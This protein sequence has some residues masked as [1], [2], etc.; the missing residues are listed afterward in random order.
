V[1]NLSRAH[2]YPLEGHE[3]VPE[4]H[5][6]DLVQQ[7]DPS[8]LDTLTLDD[9][10]TWSYMNQSSYA[11]SDQ[12]FADEA[13]GMALPMLVSDPPPLYPFVETTAQY[14]SSYVP[15]PSEYITAPVYYNPF[16]QQPMYQYQIPPEAMP[17]PA[18]L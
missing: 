3:F 14:G 5:Q 1:Q 8:R 16:V 4:L 13:L 17:A 15:F 9:S 2:F 6:F 10:A 12:G 18:F 11:Y 7:A